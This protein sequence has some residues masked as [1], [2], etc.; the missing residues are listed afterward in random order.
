[1]KRKLADP[2]DPTRLAGPASPAE[3][4]RTLLASPAGVRDAI[5]VNEL[6]AKPLALRPRGVPADRPVAPSPMAAVIA[7][8]SLGGGEPDTDRV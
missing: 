4:L 3:R 1:M 5:L 8:G 7:D 2:A 6:L